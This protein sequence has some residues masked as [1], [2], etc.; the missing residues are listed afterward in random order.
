MKRFIP[1]LAFLL[2]LAPLPALAQFGPIVP[3]VCRTC[4]C[5]FGGVLAIIQ[6]VI[7][8]IIAISI[9]IATIIIAWAGGLYMLSATNPE[10]RSLANKML[11]NAVVGLC[12]VLSAWLIVD[13]VMK[14]LYNSNSEFGPWN[15]IL[16]GGSGN[17]CIVSKKTK[18]LFK[19]DITAV[20]GQGGGTGTGG[21]GSTGTAACPL[22]VSLT[23]LG[24]SCKSESSCTLNRGVASGLVTLKEEFD[25]EWTITEA[26]PPTPGVTHK[27]PCHANGMCVDVGFRGNTTY[28]IDNIIKFE[29]AIRKTGLYT[30]FETED[31]AFRDEV[32]RRYTRAFCKSDPGYEHIR[33]N[34][35]SV[36]AN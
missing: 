4:P 5:G 15:S 16:I 20:P 24:L 26:Y 11:I 14:T 6:N 30:I 22:C 36:Y 19:G 18:P 21:T 12:I 28:T 2:L 9:I 10:S 25:G 34:H 13:F 3:D 8:F 32:K 7:N 17:S 33:G 27:N 1:L 23:S 35:F 29:L 31:C